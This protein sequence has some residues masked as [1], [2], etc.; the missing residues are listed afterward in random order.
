MLMGKMQAFEYHPSNLQL[1]NTHDVGCF[2][3]LALRVFISVVVLLLDD[4][5]LVFIW[6]YVYGG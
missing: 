5:F 2:L 6:S 4:S 3:D 1:T